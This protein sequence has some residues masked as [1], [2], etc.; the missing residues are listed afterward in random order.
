MRRDG[1]ARRGVGLSPPTRGSP[2]REGLQPRRLRSIPAHTG[3]PGSTCWTRRPTTVYPRPHGEA[4]T[5]TDA[6]G[7][8]EGLSPPTRGS[9]EG[10]RGGRLP[11][12]SIPAHTGKPTPST[13]TARMRRVYP[14]PHGEAAVLADDRRTAQGLS[15][16]TRGSRFRRRPARRRTGSI[17]AHTGKPLAARRRA[18]LA[19]VYPRP[20]GEASGNGWLAVV[21][22]GLS[23]PTRGSLKIV[24]FMTSPE[25]SIPAHTGK[26]FPAGRRTSTRAV[27]PRPHGEADLPQA[28]P[29]EDCG[30]SP[31]TRG[32][33]AGWHRPASLRGSIPAHTG[34]PRRKAFTDMA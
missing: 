30:L 32:S 16:P 18:R 22:H 5:D 11:L 20:H 12:G 3:K 27:Y 15:P 29:T 9:R 34:K 19:T 6:D 25:G 13:T 8:M 1:S 4:Y 26:P 33:P 31:P 17:P 28:P 23:P 2:V 7:G 10:G 14:R 24:R 21:W